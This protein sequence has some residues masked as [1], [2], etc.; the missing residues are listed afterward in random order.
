MSL[1]IPSKS[2]HSTIYRGVW[3]LL[4]SFRVESQTKCFENMLDM[5]NLTYFGSQV[6]IQMSA[7]TARADTGAAAY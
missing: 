6:S 7:T 2:L 1:T 4:S 5:I 3:Q